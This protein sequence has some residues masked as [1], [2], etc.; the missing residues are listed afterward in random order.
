MRCGCII[1]G[2]AVLGA[3]TLFSVGCGDFLNPNLLLQFGID[4]N[5]FT[6][7]TGTVIVMF[8]NTSQG[9]ATFYAFAAADSADLSK[10][11]RNFS[12]EVPPGKSRN[13]VLYCPVDEVGP[14]SLSASFSIQ[15]RAV[16][17]LTAGGGAS[18]VDYAGAPLISPGDFSCGDLIVIELNQD[19]TAITVQVVPS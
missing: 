16:D 5:A 12:V 8:N 11:S 14:G 15:A 1:A 4:P 18:S 7:P 6:A 13:E 3:L 19:G 17:V 2:G 10:D 9:Q